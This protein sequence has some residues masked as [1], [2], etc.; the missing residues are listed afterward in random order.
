[1]LPIDLRPADTDVRKFGFIALL[2]FPV[3]GFALTIWPMSGALP[4]SAW[5]A[6]AGLGGF[7]G[8]ASALGLVALVRPVYVGLTLVGWPIGFVVSHVLLATIYL[9]MFT[10]MAIVFRLTGRDPMRKK[11]HGKVD[12]YWIV[13]E[14][15]RSPA[16]YLRLY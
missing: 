4:V 6:F 9:L 15:Q 7:C 13:R 3:M 5:W 14:K 8:L 2:G 11:P 12:S 10:P 1:M 16:S